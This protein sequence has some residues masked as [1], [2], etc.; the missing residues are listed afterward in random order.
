M[1]NIVGNYFRLAAP[2]RK[3]GLVKTAYVRFGRFR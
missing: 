1:S 2:D 3:S